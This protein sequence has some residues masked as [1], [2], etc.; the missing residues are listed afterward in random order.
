MPVELAEQQ[1]SM[2]VDATGEDIRSRWAR[3]AFAAFLA[4]Y[5]GLLAWFCRTKFMA[6]DELL[7]FYTD[8]APSVARMVAI[9]R[10]FPVSLDPLLFHLAAHGALQFG[11]APF[12][13][14]RLPSLIGAVVMVVCIHRFT[15]RLS[16]RVTAAL[17]VVGLLI[18]NQFH[19]V[20]ARP[21]G[22]LLGL[23][24]LSLVLWQ[25]A[26]RGEHRKASLLGLSLSLGAAISSHY[27]GI[28]LVLPFAIAECLRAMRR[29]TFDLGLSA[30]ILASLVFVAGW[31]PFLAGAHQYKSNYY[32]KVQ[33][34]DL[35]RAY[36]S[37][38]QSFIG[39]HAPALE[40]LTCAIVLVAVVL[41]A[42]KGYLR[43]MQTQS[44]PS[45]QGLHTEWTC[46][47][48]FA[49]LPV[50]GV[51][52]AWAASGA[53]EIRYV[54]EFS[55]GIAICLAAGLVAIVRNRSLL[56]GLVFAGCML[57][58]V[59][60]AKRVQQDRLDRALLQRVADQ[61]A[62]SPTLL[63]DK[64]EYLWIHAS[65]DQSAAA[66][67]AL[68]VAD[69]RREIAATGSDNIDRTVLNL[70]AIAAL[71]VLS[72]GDALRHPPTLQIIVNDRSE[73]KNWLPSALAG[74]GRKTTPVQR[75]GTDQVYQVEASGTP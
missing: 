13:A 52:L 34:S 39:A 63:T 12:F 74:S 44:A 50:A 6:F 36:T 2:V 23:A 30:A 60:L 28:L 67:N 3:Y 56:T 33:A 51:L 43:A 47:L 15:R 10:E 1:A 9:Q 19:M 65:Q 42:R 4:G 46:V 24:A 54:V 41:G 38:F 59:S 11:L 68:W 7:S 64:E 17:V 37:V 58:V 69:I 35:A 48:L 61:T 72:Y 29:R 66:A 40:W 20:E 53:F 8:R 26:L 5:T 21:Y 22:V 71:P 18:S 31:L 32:I 75:I 73:P 16:D 25:N 14:V 45:S 62:G 27:F 70:N 55:L 49:L 57:T